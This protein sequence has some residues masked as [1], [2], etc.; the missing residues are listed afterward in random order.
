MK[1]NYTKPELDQILDG[2]VARVREEEIEAA[3]V[4]DAATRVWAR[5]STESAQAATAPQSTAGAVE[6]IRNCADFQ[7]LIP[8]YLGGELT[9]ART[10]LFED[11]TLEC[12]PCRKALKLARTGG[13]SV[14]TRAVR[15]KAKQSTN[16]QITPSFRRWAIAATLVLCVGLTALV[17]VN[18]FNSGNA[19]AATI[20]AADGAVYHISEADTDALAA[21]AK[22]KQGERIRT[23]K[24]SGAVLQLADNSL[25][26]MR[27]RSE[28][29]LTESSVGTT[30]HL[31]RGNV[32]VQA[33]KQ[34]ERHLYVATPDSLVSVTGTIFSVNSGTKGSRVSVVEGEVRVKHSNREEV[35]HP[36]DQAMTS[37]S[38]EPIPV[39][40]EIAWSRNAE[41]YA[42]LLTELTAL[43]N[44][45][46]NR[47]PRPGVRYS[48]RF[49]D[50][51][52]ESTVLYAALPN[53]AQTLSESHRI[54]QE[55]ISQNPALSQWWKEHQHGPRGPELEQ[56]IQQV[57]EFGQYLGEEIVVSTELNGRGEPGGFL[58][59]GELKDAAGFR[60][61]VEQ[62]KARLATEAKGGPALQLVDDP[63]AAVEGAAKNNLYVWIRGDFFAASPDLAQLRRLAASLNAPGTNRF[64]GSPFHTRIAEIYREG[65]SL[66][67]AADLEKI[68]AR[69]MQDE[70]QKTD[71][72]QRVETFRQLG[73]LNLKH[74][75]VEQKDVAPHQT[76]SRAAL[77][78]GDSRRGIASWLAAPGPMGALD[79]V[80]PDAHVAAAFVVKDPALL[81][82]DLLGVMET[83]SP[84][85]RRRLRELETQYGLDL[86]RDFAAPLGGE[87][88]FAVDGPILPTPSWKMVFEV[89]DGAR[90]QQTFERVVEELNKH[91]AKSNLKGLQWERQDAGGGRVFY[92]LRSADF[93][94]SAH[95]AYANGYLIAA[96][97]RALVERA[98]EYQQTQNTLTRSPRFTAQLPADG[99]ANFSAVFYHNLAPLLAPLAERVAGSLPEQERTALKSMGAS[100]APTLAYAYAQGDR[101][102]V[103]SNTE[104]GPFGLSPAS[105]LG[106]PNAFEMQHILMK[107]L[108]AK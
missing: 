3:T 30:I 81:V 90:L 87:F 85:L 72:Q 36:G 43:R 55:R 68:T 53:L 103:A 75:V 33:A 63:S 70:S 35:L 32:I 29:Y 41:Q 16:W 24:E 107:A 89:Y 93:G 23:A 76:Q 50:M 102:I 80:S 54:M 88:A 67:V 25:V 48:T 52:P 47:V 31:E 84:D 42:K 15:P 11:H 1:R 56:A 94:V 74:V 66:V 79:Y 108:D 51:L 105:L 57:R 104:G 106:G 69:V 58:V 38:I 92:T 44:D 61:F 22:L 77:T 59:L 60:P 20:D 34:R 98:I 4:S 12:I 62:L 13:A 7:A 96:P 49:L 46:N 18:R 100:S 27:E 6:H 40:Q 78:F 39:K 101:I 83:A 8:D 17:F 91:A 28:I 26:E 73:L 95:Y 71:G 65:A 5:V 97:S 64:V 9:P 2:V 82:D 45:L 19:I 10:L 86:R 21:G 99:N 37:R 14:A